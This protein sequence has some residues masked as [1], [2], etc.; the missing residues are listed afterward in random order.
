MIGHDSSEI[1]ILTQC[2]DGSDGEEDSENEEPIVVDKLRRRY[3]Y[4]TKNPSSVS[5]DCEDP[6][7][8]RIPDSRDHREWR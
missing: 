5:D 8:G 1:Q 4:S 2:L 7:G 6:R 3:Y